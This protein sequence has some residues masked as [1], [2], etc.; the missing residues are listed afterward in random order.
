VDSFLCAAKIFSI[1]L[2][3]K[4]VKPT[5]MD[6][7]IYVNEPYFHPSLPGPLPFRD[8]TKH[9]ANNGA[10]GMIDLNEALVKNK[11]T[12]FFLRV[13]CQAVKDAGIHK[14]DVVIVDRSLPATDGKVVI[15]ALGGELLIRKLLIIEKRMHLVGDRLAPLVLDERDACIWGVVT[16]VIHGF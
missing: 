14:G 16:F 11:Q 1:N 8:E 7:N 12:T 3:N 6:K 4:L 15:A 9:T 13:N 2:L 5:A 10:L